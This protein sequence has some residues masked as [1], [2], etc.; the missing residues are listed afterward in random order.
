M[1]H[2]D[3]IFAKTPADL[4]Q[5]RKRRIYFALERERA[6]RE[7]LRRLAA[8]AR[9]PISRPRLE[10]L[11]ERLARPRQ[12]SKWRIH[13]WQPVNTRVMLAAQFKAGKTTLVGNLI[14][15]LVDVDPFLACNPVSPITGTAVLLDFEMS[16]SQ[17]DDWYRDI[18]IRHDDRVIVEPMRG[19]ASTFDLCD[20]DVRAEW[21]ARL[22]SGGAAYLILDCLRPVLDALALDE[23]KDAGRF[24][25]AFDALLKDAG[26][27]E[28]LVVQHMGHVNE[29]A[30]GDSRQRDWPDVEWRLVRQDENPASDRFLSAYGRDVDVS[31]SQLAYDPSTR[32][33]TLVGG[34]RVDAK[35]AEALAAVFDVLRTEA[36]LSGRA[37]KEA[38]ADSE[39]PRDTIDRALKSGS[40]SGALKVQAGPRKSKLYSL[41][42]SD[43]PAVSGECPADTESECPAA[44]IKPDART[45]AQYTLHPDPIPDTPAIPFGI[46]PEAW[47][48]RH[49][50]HQ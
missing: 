27:G 38:L 31:E 7:A 21:A 32:R 25:V 23:H 41:P 43:C 3:E 29:R 10:T 49:G 42:V 44:Y 11:R 48:A 33:L 12:L 13:G 6:R 47:A 15:S 45:D 26:I 50:G 1:L 9:G 8:E 24:L 20:P 14:R 35:T 37:I 4:E 22:R 40:Q 46:S 5:A 18:C 2:E 34:S 30:R 16:D 36:P 17:L 39:H 19:R 28:A